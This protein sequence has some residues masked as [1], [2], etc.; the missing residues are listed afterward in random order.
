MKRTKTVENLFYMIKPIWEVSPAYVII[1]VL[2]TFENIPRR[3]LDVMIVKLIVDAAVAGEEFINIIIKGILLLVAELFLVVL[4]HCFTQMYKNPKEIEICAR[5]KTNLFD[6]IKTIDIENYDNKEFYDKYTY[7]FCS[8]DVTAFK[9]FNTMLKLSGSVIAALTLSS[10][11][12]LLSPILIILAVAGSAVSLMSNFLVSKYKVQHQKER[13]VYDRKIEYISG[14]YA[15]RQNAADIKMG[16][17]PSLLDDFFN[18][19][20]K[21][22][23]NLEKKYGKKY[24]FFNI[25]FE[26]PLNITDMMMWLYIA[27][28]ILNG[29]LKV[30][31]FMSLSNAAWSLSQQLRN[32]FNTFPVFHELSMTIENILVLDKYRSK[33]VFSNRAH[34][35][36][37]DMIRICI[38]DVSFTY[39]SLDDFEAKILKGINF[40]MKTG[41][42]IALVGQNGAGKTTIVKL[43]LRMYDP[44][45]GAIML[46]GHSYNE[47]NLHE[48]RS[49]FSVVFQ[50]FQYYSFSIAE[51]ILLRKPRDEHD[52]D[53]VDFTLRKVGLY[54]KIHE[55]PLGIDTPLT[56]N[57]DNE[58]VILSG[59]EFQKLVIARA[60]AQDS[61]VVIMDEP[62]SALDPLSEREISDLLLNVFQNKLVFIISHR[63]SMTKN[64]DKIMVIDKGEIVEQGEHNEL[65]ALNGKYAQLWNAQSEYFKE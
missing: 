46:N 12:A 24:T 49:I 21:S 2:Y 44:S 41:E 57:F 48:L 19:A 62:S 53:I 15:A 16:L 55:T 1:N 61:P 27:Y 34:L 10:Y 14:I 17:I 45:A 54:K 28:G 8:A 13:V 59:G 30:G 65:V 4:K 5:I 25:I 60:L 20:C 22:K 51:N 38:R 58:G 32:I 63:L 43:L 18:K 42:K 50:D 35:K 29:F 26:S 36:S 52:R 23:V 56:K 40:D 3:L 39:P 47:Y 7:A 31:D 33:L 37:D 64:C 9:V 6:K 11:M